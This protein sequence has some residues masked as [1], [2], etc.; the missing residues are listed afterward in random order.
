M[1]TPLRLV[2]RLSLLAFHFHTLLTKICILDTAILHLKKCDQ[3]RSVLLAFD[4][5]C[6]D[7]W[8]R[9][10]TLKVLN[11]IPPTVQ[12]VR[13][14][15]PVC[16]DKPYVQAFTSSLQSVLRRFHH[17][18]LVVFGFKHG[19]AMDPQIASA[20]EESVTQALRDLV[21]RDIFIWREEPWEAFDD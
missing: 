12:N 6:L 1:V 11:A 20:M 10:V 7:T 4:G 13:V 3:L 16:N 2:S 21:T 19:I 14:Q 9:N 8:W 15:I 5:W 17:L 18:R